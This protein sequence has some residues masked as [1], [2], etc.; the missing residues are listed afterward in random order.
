MSYIQTTQPK[1]PS[2]LQEFEKLLEFLRRLK[3]DTT[4]CGDFNIDTIKASKDKSDYEKLLSAFDFKRQ[5][6]N[7]LE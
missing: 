4:L 3:N 7:L 1:I 5:I 2:F 6:L